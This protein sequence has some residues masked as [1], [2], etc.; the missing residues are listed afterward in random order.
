MSYTDLGDSNELEKKD[1]G[2]DKSY[3]KLVN[4]GWE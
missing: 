1:E 3:N 4:G 2:F